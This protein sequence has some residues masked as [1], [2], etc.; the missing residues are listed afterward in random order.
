[1]KPSPAVPMNPISAMDFIPQEQLHSIQLARLREM[2]ELA[3]ANVPLFKARL[4]E[5]GIK[6]DDI[7]KIEDIRH[8]PFT[9]K[10]DLRDT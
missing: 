4:D 3:Y 1:M 5:R 10:A 7:R 2:V 6:P 8:L 9:V